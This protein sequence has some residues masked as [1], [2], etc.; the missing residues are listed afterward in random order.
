M[1]VPNVSD[2]RT[3]GGLAD[4]KESRDNPLREGEEKIEKEELLRGGSA[5]IRASTHGK[6]LARITILSELRKGD[7]MSTTRGSAAPARM[8]IG[9]TSG[10]CF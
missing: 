1:A 6:G 5:S 7:G 3:S 10:S 8:Q 2:S 4:E 9:R